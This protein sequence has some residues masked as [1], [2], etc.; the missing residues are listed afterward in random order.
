MGLDDPAKKM[1]KSA[2]SEYNYISLLDAPNQVEKKIMK[3]V[4]DSGPD[5]RFDEKKK[6]AVSNLLTIFSLLSGESIKNLESR[7]AG[8][9]YGVF[10]K[11]LVIAVNDFLQPFQKRFQE[12]SE[13]SKLEKIL[14]QGKK[15]AEQVA[16]KTLDQVK[17]VLGLG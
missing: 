13:S 12:F 6:P 1:S 3:A 16:E 5:I 11:D 14:Q 8:K 10:K 17:T 2:L 9:G 4:T 15:K 7:Y